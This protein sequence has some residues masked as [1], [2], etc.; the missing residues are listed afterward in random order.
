MK[1]ALA[2]RMG[3]YVN[4]VYGNLDHQNGISC[5]VAS[6]LYSVQIYGDFAGYSLMAIGVAKTLG[7]N[8]VNNFNRPYFS[9]SITEFW[10]RWHIS[11]SIW[12]RDYIYIP[13]GGS[14]CSKLKIIG[15]FMLLFWFRGYGMGQIGHSSFG[16]Y[17]TDCFRVLRNC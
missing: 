9:I 2:D 5:L 12:L 10:R 16:G 6:I 13:L 4:T 1:V 8:L 14:R 15:I 17:Y 3:I 11:L 7:I